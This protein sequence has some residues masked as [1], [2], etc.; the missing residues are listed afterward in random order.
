VNSNRTDSEYTSTRLTSF[1]SD[2]F[3]FATSDVD[4]NGSGRTYVA[5]NW[6]AGNGTASNTDGSITSTVSANVAAGFSV[7]GWTGNGTSGAT[8]GH[9]LSSAP[10]FFMVKNRSNTD[11][12]AILE[13]V[14]NG[15]THYL[16]LPSSAV[17][18]P[19]STFWTDTNPTS[20]VITLGTQ[21]RSNGSGDS[22]IGYAWHSVEGF[23]KFGSY[24]GN[25]S[26][27][28]TF[29]YTGFKPAFVLMKKTSG[30]SNWIMYD[31]ARDPVNFVNKRIY[32]NLSN[33]EDPHASNDHVDFLS[34]GFK[35]RSSGTNIN[36]SGTYVYLAF[37]S[38][39]FGGDGVAPVPAR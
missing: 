39:P 10:E 9:G 7:I 19:N 29:I 27:N 18:N 34:N 6:L 16:T 8:I 38:N 22:M 12:W 26:T 4:T 25:G 31:A 14:V 30:T 15:G 3:S 37:A 24:T 28:G 11:Y 13:T 32:T 1:D 33:A 2:G 17:S 5:W 35:Q 20:S 36:A 21:N 23:S